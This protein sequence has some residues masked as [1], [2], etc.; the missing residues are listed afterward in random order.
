[1]EQGPLLD[2]LDSYSAFDNSHEHQGAQLDAN[3]VTCRDD[4]GKVVLKAQIEPLSSEPSLTLSLANN[5]AIASPFVTFGSEA[6]TCPQGPA[7]PTCSPSSQ[8]PYRLKAHN[9][10]YGNHYYP[11]F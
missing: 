4:E 7:K 11:T 8:R 10:W 3:P 2:L 5:P 6:G 1:M 9:L